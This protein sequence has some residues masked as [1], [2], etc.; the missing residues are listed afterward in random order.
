MRTTYNVSM[1]LN[2]LEINE[3]IIDEH[4][5]INHSEMSDFIILSLIKKLN[6]C[7]RTPAQVSLYYLYFV[8]EPIFLNEKPYRLIIVLEKGKQYIGVVNAFRVKEK[9]YGISF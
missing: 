4:Y 8:E 3:V 7:S 1:V 2:D 5:K 9:K 6:G